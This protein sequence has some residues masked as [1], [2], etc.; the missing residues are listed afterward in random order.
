MPEQPN[1]PHPQPPLA[2]VEADLFEA[3]F[4]F[5]KRTMTLLRQ[6]SL[7][8]EKLSVIAD[9]INTLLDNVTGE[10]KRTQKLNV[11]GRLE[12]AYDEIRRLVDELS[13]FPDG[14]KNG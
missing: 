14:G 6:S 5:H 7:N 12:A 9:R 8:D 2:S 4:G 3:I 11:T 1:N 13:G 10:M